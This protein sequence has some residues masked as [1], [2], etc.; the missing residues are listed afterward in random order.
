MLLSLRGVS[1][2]RVAAARADLAPVECADAITDPELGVSPHS[3]GSELL[4]GLSVASKLARTSKPETIDALKIALSGLRGYPWAL[5]LL[6]A[7]LADFRTY[8]AGA[9]E[10]KTLGRDAILTAFTELARVGVL[11]NASV[12]RARAR[13]AALFPTQRIDALDELLLPPWTAPLPANAAERALANTSAYWFA[14]DKTM[15]NFLSSYMPALAVGVPFR[16]CPQHACDDY[17]RARLDLGRTYWR[18]LDFIEAAYA[19]KR[20]AD[21]MVGRFATTDL[22]LALARDLAHGPHDATDM[23]GRRGRAFGLDRTE[24]LDALAAEGGPSSGMAAFDAAHLRSLSVP[25]DDTA[26]D[27]L[28]DLARR[29]EKSAEMLRHPPHRARAVERARRAH[30]AATAARLPSSA[31]GQR[32]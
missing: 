16:N 30:A 6:E 27:Y 24:A 28:E 13:L 12:S 15:F 20:H 32:E 17:A 29:F 11:R 23:M 14:A 2:V 25:E 3:I 8:D 19:A 4:I 31:D 7:G 1:S 18:R 26:P 5:A 9:R 22:L 10:R 21:A